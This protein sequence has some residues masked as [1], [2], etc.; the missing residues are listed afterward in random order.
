MTK[1]LEESYLGQGQG[2]LTAPPTLATMDGY[3]HLPSNGRLH[4]K[5]TEVGAPATRQA[6]FLDRDGVL[7][8]D[9]HFRWATTVNGYCSGNS[10]RYHVPQSRAPWPSV[11][12]RACSVG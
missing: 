7:V 2:A 11:S 12:C 3:L 6:V 9:V 5:G 8:E 1:A 4:H 10:P